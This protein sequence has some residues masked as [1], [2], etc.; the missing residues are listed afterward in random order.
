MKAEEA[1]VI[2]AE[3]G[4]EKLV[5]PRSPRYHTL[6][7]WRG[8]ACLMVV[9]S[10]STLY[11]TDPSVVAAHGWLYWSIAF[12]KRLWIGV[13][14]FFVISG[15][16]ISA[17]ADASRDREQPGAEYFLRRL[18][19]IYPPYWI[20]F[21]VVAFSVWL[22]ENY[23]SPGFFNDH[24]V[25]VGSANSLTAI[26]WL[27]NLTLTENWRGYYLGDVSNEFLAHAWTLGY[28][29][30][31]YAITGLALLL[32]PG[33]LFES[34]SAVS[35]GTVAA[36]E[37]LP[38]LG[39]STPGLFVDGRWLMFAAGILVY[40]AVN[41]AGYIGRRWSYLL[42]FLAVSYAA[43]DPGKLLLTLPN[44]LDQSFFVAFVFAGVSLAL[45][46][47]DAQ[48]ASWIVAKPLIF[49]GR[50]CYSLYL[51]HWPVVKIVSRV[52]SNGGINSYAETLFVT[53]PVCLIVSMAAA[54]GFHLLV[55]RHFM[56]T[57]VSP[58]NRTTQSS[59]LWSAIPS[60]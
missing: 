34:F 9:V 21:F 46:G 13:P 18:R 57:W 58:F 33:R 38:L 59:S 22:V 42:L 6:D 8:V 45:H 12:T 48:T 31:F 2:I 27:G 28:E 36:M 11:A 30:Q 56:N 16:C 60:R 10:H 17:T 49:C 39:I 35:V 37:I 52:L 20:W 51:V 5:G 15:Y 43:R 19:R 32:S 50:M 47:R 4:P 26:Q 1:K 55:E 40:Y 23:G 24:T 25:P 44:N 29:E 3:A 41:Y 53:I 7:L 54:W 14:I